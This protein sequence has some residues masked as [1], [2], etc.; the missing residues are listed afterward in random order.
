MSKYH[1]LYLLW[2]C[3]FVSNLQAQEVVTSQSVKIQ[4]IK[5][6][7]TLTYPE[8]DPETQK[9]TDEHQYSSIRRRGGLVGG[10]NY[11]TKQ[12]TKSRSGASYSRDQITKVGYKSKG[13][14]GNVETLSRDFEITRSATVKLCVKPDINLSGLK[15][16]LEARAQPVAVKVKSKPGKPASQMIS[17]KT[18]AAIDA[19]NK[20]F[21]EKVDAEIKK[22]LK[23][24]NKS[25]L[26]M[27][28]QELAQLWSKT[29]IEKEVAFSFMKASKSVKVKLRK[30]E[31]K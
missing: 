19:D 31:K 15:I 18:A 23:Q 24:I 20:K 3:I 30:V 14:K 12:I 17:A 6:C 5:G 26:K 11:V 29:G 22:T 7:I 13:K 1:T 28:P 25:T 21:K 2:I 9:Y 8:K 10:V 16:S 27:K 4:H